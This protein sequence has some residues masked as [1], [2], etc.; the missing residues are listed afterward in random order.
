M[1]IQKMSLN[2]WEMILSK[3]NIS[4]RILDMSIVKFRNL[5]SHIFQLYWYC[6]ETLDMKM[7]FS[8][9]CK[10]KNLQIPFCGYRKLKEQICI[11]ACLETIWWQLTSTPNRTMFSLDKVFCLC[12]C[13]SFRKHGYYGDRTFTVDSMGQE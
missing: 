8:F 3:L 12:V 1:I 4:K 11:R 9:P 13:L 7:Y 6:Q 10:V 5:L 2:F